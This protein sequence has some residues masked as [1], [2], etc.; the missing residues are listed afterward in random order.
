MTRKLKPCGTAAGYGR[1]ISRGEPT[2]EPCRAAWRE[3]QQQYD[4]ATGRTNH[5]KSDIPPELAPCGTYGAAQRHKAHGEPVCRACQRAFRNYQ[6]E[7]ARDY[8]AAKKARREALDAL[9]TKAWAEVA[10]P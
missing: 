9:L 10:G 8:R 2:C 7:K 4:R 3:Y 1:H 6:A 5:D